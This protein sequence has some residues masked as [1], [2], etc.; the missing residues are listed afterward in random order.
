MRSTSICPAA[1][2]MKSILMRIIRLHLV[3]YSLQDMHLEQE[4]DS[5]SNGAETSQY[6]LY[7]KDGVREYFSSSGK[8]IGIQD[9]YDNTI[10]LVHSTQ[11]GFPHIVITDTLS[12][13][14]VISGQSTENGHDIIV[15]A[16]GNITLTYHV[17]EADTVQS[18]AS[19]EDAGDRTTHYSYTLQ[20]AGF[21]AVSKTVSESSNQYLNLTTRSPI[22]P[23]PRRSMPM[24]KPP[25]IWGRAA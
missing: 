24:R 21:S 14:V 22:R 9:R 6:T 15:S 5:F 13:T 16:P 2:P 10:T 7:Y 23:W 1:A 3:D 4:S 17:Q 20:S 11:N 25:A 18:L 8:L 12:R 19:Y